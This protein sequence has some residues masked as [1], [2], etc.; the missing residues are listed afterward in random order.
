MLTGKHLNT[1][2]AL[3]AA[4]LLKQLPRHKQVFANRP[5]RFAHVAVLLILVCPANVQVFLASRHA[6]NH[7]RLPEAIIVYCNTGCS[8][9][10][11]KNAVSRIFFVP[12][13]GEKRRR[14]EDRLHVDFKTANW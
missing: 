13:A 5:I 3:R 6:G 4:S 14:R 2:I 8:G 9:G 7:A 11:K 10:E 12:E 1:I